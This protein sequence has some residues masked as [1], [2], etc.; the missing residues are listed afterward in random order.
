MID[1]V[2]LHLNDKDEYVL[3]IF[4]DVAILSY[5]V[6]NNCELVINYIHK[7]AEVNCAKDEPDFET[8]LWNDDGKALNDELDRYCGICIDSQWF[9]IGDN[10]LEEYLNKIRLYLNK[11]IVETNLEEIEKN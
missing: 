1:I 6:E 11:E 3:T 7:H 2:T 9:P 5:E 10:S 4:H 8:F